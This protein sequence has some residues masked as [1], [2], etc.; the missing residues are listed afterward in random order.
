MVNL[1]RP[2]IR[3]SSCSTSRSSYLDHRGGH[4]ARQGLS[5]GDRVVVISGDKLSD[6]LGRGILISVS[7]VQYAGCKAGTDHRL[8]RVVVPVMTA[9]HIYIQCQETAMPP[10]QGL[11]VALQVARHLSLQDGRQV[12]CTLTPNMTFKLK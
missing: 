11:R 7:G 5:A 2:S 8:T 1:C 12:W 6:D 3:R 9:P 4:R 10:R